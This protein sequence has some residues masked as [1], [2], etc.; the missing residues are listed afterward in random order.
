MSRQSQVSEVFDQVVHDDNF[1][2]QKV[3]QLSMHCL[4]W[5]APDACVILNPLL[6]IVVLNHFHRFGFGDPLWIESTLTV[7]VLVGSCLL[8]SCL[9]VFHRLIV[10]FEYA[11]YTVSVKVEVDRLH[12]CLSLNEGARIVCLHGLFVFIKSFLFK[13]LVK[14]CGFTHDGTRFHLKFRADV[15]ILAFGA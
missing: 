9:V 12:L 5:L 1:V 10:D 4:E 8:S 7:N 15:F 13:K 11:V 2:S 6:S 14:L 3:L